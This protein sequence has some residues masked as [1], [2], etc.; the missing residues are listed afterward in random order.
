MYTCNGLE[1]PVPGHAQNKSQSNLSSCHPL[2]FPPCG[3]DACLCHHSVTWIFQHALLNCKACTAYSKLQHS[4]QSVDD[5][6]TY[7]LCCVKHEKR[8]FLFHL[9][10][11]FV[12]FT[13]VAFLKTRT[14]RVKYRKLNCVLRQRCC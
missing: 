1:L 14:V 7:L 9:N 3:R 11:L 5:D 4:D 6:A 13:L 12:C 10:L 8:L 2:Y